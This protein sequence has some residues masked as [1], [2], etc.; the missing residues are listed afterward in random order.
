MHFTRQVLPCLLALLLVTSADTA[1]AKKKAKR[2]RNPRAAATQVAPAPVAPAATATAL[3]TEIAPIVDADSAATTEAVVPV[4]EPSNPPGVEVIAASAPLSSIAEAPVAA[5]GTAVE[6]TTTVT[7]PVDAKSWLVGAHLG[8][9]VPGVVS[10]LGVGGS[11]G[12]DVGYLLP[13]LEQR[14]QVYGRFDYLR[15]SY[16][17]SGD[18]PRLVTST[19]YSYKVIEEELVVGLGA[20]ARLWQPG[21][22]LNVYGRLGG[23]TRLQ[24]STARGR[25]TTSLFG[26][27]NETKTAAGLLLGGGG[28]LRFGPGVAFAELD[29]SYADLHHAITGDSATGGLGLL[30]GYAMMF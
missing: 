22:Y 5:M 4:S 1:L 24:R 29:L 20:V 16:T 10:K 11:G 25:A 15:P 6:V 2:K 27:N 8:A 19:S 30:A 26:E 13:W 21:S 28:E 7:A 14:V 23:E 9:A 17:A 12:I 18:D 3:A